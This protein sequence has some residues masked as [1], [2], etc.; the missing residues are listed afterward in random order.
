M[1]HWL[2]E[3]DFPDAF[4]QTMLISGYGF[5]QFFGDFFAS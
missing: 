5:F 4:F 3:L 1:G 2:G